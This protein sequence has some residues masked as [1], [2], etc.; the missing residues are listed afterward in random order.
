MEFIQPEE[1][2]IPSMHKLDVSWA[3]K[4]KNRI[5]R[6]IYL[7][8]LKKSVSLVKKP[9]HKFVLDIGTGCGIL[10]PTLNKYGKKVVGI[11]ILDRFH[12]L[13]DFVNKEKLGNTLLI[14][15]D[16]LNLPFKKGCFDLIFCLSVLEHVKNVDD[17]LNEIKR[18]LDKR[19]TFVLGYP[20]D[21]SL[22]NLGY[23]YAKVAESTKKQHV[24]NYKILR[25]EL[26]SYFKI[27]KK[28]KYPSNYLPDFLSFYEAN[29][30][31]K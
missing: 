27:M 26:E 2:N 12:E 6:S 5:I 14:K 16:V 19:G 28:I 3:Y 11:D 25:N 9:K 30:C 10:L 15:A 4:S 8:R 13:K 22:T 29:K 18:T 21:S 20:I 24:S 17:A 31:K 1:K 23:R 7:K